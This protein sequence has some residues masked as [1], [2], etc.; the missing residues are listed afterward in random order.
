[1]GRDVKNLTQGLLGA[2]K[3]KGLDTARISGIMDSP[4]G[5]ALMARLNAPEGEAMKAAA[6]KAASGDTAALSAL[7]GTLMATKEGQ[8]VAGQVMNLKKNG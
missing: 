8:S 7:L 2:A 4:E 1:M 3:A 5:R 6:S